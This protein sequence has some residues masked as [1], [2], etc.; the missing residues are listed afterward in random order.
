M[1]RNYFVIALRHIRRQL[2]Y[3]FINILGLAVGLACSLVI[4]LFVYNEW[5][6]DRHFKQADQIYR[7][8]ISFF[9]MGQFAN[10]PELLADVVRDEFTGVKAF[11]RF[12]K[13]SEEIV[14]VKNEDFKEVVYFVD[15]SFFEV[16]SYE[17]IK[18]NSTTA[19]AE[20]N[21]AVITESMAWK[22]FGTDKVIGEV[23]DVGKERTPYHI[24]GLV[25]DET[26]PSHLK[27]SIWVSLA[28]PKDKQF[29]W[30]A[31][32]VYNYMLV[33]DGVTE[34]QVSDLLDQVVEK[35][36][37]PTS[38][39]HQEGQSLE[40][41][42][43]DPNAVKFI[44][45]PLTDIYLKSKLSL[46]LSP[47]GNLANIRIFGAIAVIILILAAVNFVNL[48]T[49]RA[50]R[51]A[52]E[53]GVRKSL[54]TS[55]SN[56]IAQFLL[57]SIIISLVS[58]GMALAFAEIFGLVFHWIAGQS[59][60]I[61][62]VS[63][64]TNIGAVVMFAVG[65]GVLAGLYPAF[66][67]TNFETASVLKGTLKLSASSAFRNS[68]I[69]F[70]FCISIGLII[71]TI[72]IF[73]QMNYMEV[74]DLG[75]EQDNRITI[76][77]L[78]QMKNDVVAYRDFIKAQPGVIDATL[79]SG[80]P[81]SKAVMYFYTYQTA[82]MPQALTINTYFGDHAFIDVMG[83]KLL[84]GRDFNKELVSDSSSVILNQ[85]AVAAL[86]LENPIGAEINK[87]MK[88]IGVVND[89][90]WESLRSEIGPLVIM[91]RGDRMKDLPYTQLAIEVESKDTQSILKRAEAR[92]K[93]LVPDEPFNYHYVDENFGALLQKETILA[94]AISF[95]TALAIIISCLG[96]FGLSAYTAETRTK[97]IGIRKV[98]GASS[99]NIMLLLNRQFT[100]LILISAVITI[101][102]VVL[103]CNRW[104][105][106]FA[107]HTSLSI[108]IVVL[109]ATTAW[110]MSYITALYHT[111]KAARGNPVETLKYE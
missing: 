12:Q 44:L 57:E 95:F 87:G 51:R 83:F 90:H 23:L 28:L 85:S 63:E 61:N 108:W 25:K 70:Q 89:F 49:A 2:L 14:R 75:F 72:V 11:T 66:Y 6:H 96:L 40:Q 84:K 20:P 48:S 26:A 46:Q 43:A 53:V 3:S 91:H 15:S 64:W 13:N 105:R 106:S 8:G 99:A 10:G 47:G 41:Y 98:L 103:L 68:L 107:Y 79:H 45:E 78:F 60:A 27:S 34:K 102:V 39:A 50:S 65:V 55:R 38:W 88:V 104:L 29:H 73:R 42:K 58:M 71:F 5:S 37:Y 67:M 62:L 32:S 22:Y 80:E 77:N 1:I 97:E 74:K 94:K 7:V 24:T 33:E 17:L 56:L 110:L 4:F 81:G 21:S 18:G 59:L 76:D 100:V 9:N 54:G 101:P 69:V 111:M 16:F 82:S 52:K 86:G 30:T 93:Q 92:W 36:V 109:G 19:L 31:A 35:H